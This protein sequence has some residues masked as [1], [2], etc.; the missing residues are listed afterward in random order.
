MS[1]TNR[2]GGD[3]ALVTGAS[4]GIGRAIALALAAGRRAGRSA[5]RRARQARRAISAELAPLGGRGAV[6]RRRRQASPSALLDQL[7]GRRADA[8]HPGQQ[9][10]H[11]ARQL[12][13]RMREEDWDAVVDTN[14]PANFRITKACI[15]RMMKERRGRIINIT[16]VVGL[17]GNAGQA[18]YA[19]AKAGV[20]GLT[21]SLAR[22][23]ASRNITVNAVAPGFIDTDMTRSLQ[24]GAQA[25]AAGRRFR[26][27][28]SA[29]PRTSPRPCCSWPPRRPPISRG[30]P[31]ASMA[32]C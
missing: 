23:V 25:A 9:R 19:A 15:K 14:L 27:D 28:G 6:L 12:L 24:R 1:Q 32:G 16:S 10:G 13:L 21:K 26:P 20:I 22:E 18:N 29:A 3:T 2:L 7:D 8:Q 4:R 31:S 5:R 30:K 17:M 11:H